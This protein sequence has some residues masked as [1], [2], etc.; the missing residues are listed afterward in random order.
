MF[1]GL[2]VL[3]VLSVESMAHEW[4]A[5]EEAATLANPLVPDKATVTWGKQVYH[6]NCA[7]CHG[8]TLEG[9]P[10][11]DT[12]LTKDTPNLKRSLKTHSEGDMFWKIRTGRGDMPAF[13]QTLSEKDTWAVITYIKKEI[14]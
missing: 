9:L 5:P 3:A 10:A 1:L 14:R 11:E 13:K 2:L 6:N 12:G 4:M 7:Y 8:Q